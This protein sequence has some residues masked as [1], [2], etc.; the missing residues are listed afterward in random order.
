MNGKLVL[1]C[2]FCKY[3]LDTLNQS[4]NG[5]NQVRKRG[6]IDRRASHLSEI[7]VPKEL[8]N[9]QVANGREFLRRTVEDVIQDFNYLHT[10]QKERGAI[11]Y[12]PSSRYRVGYYLVK[13]ITRTYLRIGL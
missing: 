4:L 3:R 13:E 7:D 11:P 10:G 1:P 2:S 5:F 9:R 8:E 12:N 6:G